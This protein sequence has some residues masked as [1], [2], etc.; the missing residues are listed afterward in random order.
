MIKHLACIELS[1]REGNIRMPILP[2]CDLS[3]YLV[4]SYTGTKVPVV[5]DT[6]NI[7]KVFSKDMWKPSTDNRC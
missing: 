2:D 1:T 4:D 7:V 5:F 6:T 3:S